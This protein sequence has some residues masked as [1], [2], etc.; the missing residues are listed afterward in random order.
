MIKFKPKMA[1]S[2]EMYVDGIPISDLRVVDL[3]E[4]LEKRS[5]SKS[6]SKTILVKRLKDVSY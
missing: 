4:Q 1:S 5:L 6:G 2:E 3:K